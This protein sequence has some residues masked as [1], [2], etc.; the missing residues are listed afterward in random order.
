MYRILLVDDEPLILAGIASL[1]PWEDYDCTVVAKSNNGANAYELI[2][3]LNPDIVIT[4]IRMPTMNGLELLEKCIDENIFFSCIILTNL[5][6]FQLAKKAVSLGAIDYLVK[7]SLTKEELLESLNKAKIQCDKL[8]KNS[9]SNHELS[10][11]AYD[12]KLLITTYLHKEPTQNDIPTKLFQS[13][14]NPVVLN[15]QL[16]HCE[17]FF[18]PDHTTISIKE[19]TPQIT[20]IINGLLKR[21]FPIHCVVN[22]SSNNFTIVVSISDV[23]NFKQTIN[24]FIN[25]ISSALKTYFELTFVC[26][27]STIGRSLLELPSLYDQSL[28]AL[29][30]YYHCSDTPTIYYKEPFVH[31]SSTN[32]FNINFL[33]KELKMS[34]HQN[35]SEKL[36][37]IFQQIIELFKQYK[38]CKNQSISACINIYTFIYSEFELEGTSYKEQFPYTSNIAEY[39]FQF[40]SLV[41]ILKWLEGFCSEICKILNTRNNNPSDKLVEQAKN[42][43]ND[44][45]K[46]KLILTDIADHLNI[47]TGHLSVTFKKITGITIVDYISNIKIDHAKLLLDTHQYLIYEISEEL[48]FENPYYF[49]KVFKKITGISPR[50]YENR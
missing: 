39:L 34:I 4:D 43:I 10:H 2:H 16:Q 17:I 25:K 12:E 20:D 7:L 40:A 28:N 1:L 18:H 3:Q 44:H 23:Q 33:K 11:A 5:E 47:S 30:H 37:H 38:P 49:S 41:D 26:G 19:S 21:F 36:N 32:N 6:E 8:R 24:L 9:I 22:T 31:K 35:N 50:E 45:Y 48:G 15:F 42:Y 29:E 13:Y 27:V 14:K 46:E